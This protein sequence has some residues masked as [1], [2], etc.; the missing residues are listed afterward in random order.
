MEIVCMLSESIYILGLFILPG[1]HKQKSV[2]K[3]ILLLFFPST[4]CVL[5][6]AV[7]ISSVKVQTAIGLTVDLTGGPESP[8]V[9]G[10][11]V[12]VLLN[13]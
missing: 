2:F 4:Q 6:L 11:S 13:E 9:W 12:F 3:K 7:V 1:K 10:S 5:L 8:G